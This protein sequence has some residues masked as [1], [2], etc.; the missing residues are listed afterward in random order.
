[1]ENGK[2]VICY[3]DDVP[4]FAISAVLFENFNNDSCAYR[5]LT[6]DF[7]DVEDPFEALSQ[8]LR[9]VDVLVL[10]SKLF[11][12]GTSGKCLMGESLRPF[13]Q[14][15]FPLLKIIL[16]TANGNQGDFGGLSKYPENRSGGFDDQRFYYSQELV[17][18]IMKRLEEVKSDRRAICNE[19]IARDVGEKRVEALGDALDGDSYYTR[20]TKEDTD[21]LISAFNA[22]REEMRKHG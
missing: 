19:A 2:Y 5:E 7:F 3:C 8:F 13:L 11:L 10:D 17:P 1:M 18:L 15:Y 4:S 21:G 14:F 12:D 6:Y 20:L 9:G 16:I 22:L